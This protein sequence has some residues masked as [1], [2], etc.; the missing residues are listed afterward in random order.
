MELYIGGY[1]Q[2]KFSYVS[3]K[4]QKSKVIDERDIKEIFAFFTGQDFVF[5]GNLKEEVLIWNHF[6]LCMKKCLAL[7][8]SPEEI[9]KKIGKISKKVKKFIII[10]D[11][12]GNGIVPMEKQERRYR[13]ETGRMLEFIAKNSEKVERILCGIP[14]KIK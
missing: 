5:K 10:S 1:A 9:K 2:G 6:H 8:I 12:I 11:E 13:E 14:Q 4:Y 7:G 3:E